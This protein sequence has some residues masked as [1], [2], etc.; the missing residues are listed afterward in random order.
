M[1]HH[2]R[3]VGTGSMR[4]LKKNRGREGIKE[5]ETEKRVASPYGISK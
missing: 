3:G 5:N 4:T 1:R 2:C